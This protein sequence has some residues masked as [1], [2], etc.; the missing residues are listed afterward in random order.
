VHADQANSIEWRP[1]SK[2]YST[3]LFVNR[4]FFVDL[5]D[6]SPAG[7]TQNVLKDESNSPE[8]WVGRAHRVQ[9]FSERQI[10]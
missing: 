2:L 1:H 4:Y 7:R 9:K 3:Y 5:P 10:L 6:I 8:V